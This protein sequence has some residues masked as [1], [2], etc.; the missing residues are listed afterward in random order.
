MLVFA[1]GTTDEYVDLRMHAPAAHPLGFAPA[2]GRVALGLIFLWQKEQSSYHS[3]F[4]STTINA[5]DSDMSFPWFRCNDDGR[6][7]ILRLW[8]LPRL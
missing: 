8:L 6:G 2:T 7:W 5:L 3:G 1:S 4:E